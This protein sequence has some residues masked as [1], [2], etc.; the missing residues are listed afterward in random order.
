MHSK[1]ADTN[2]QSENSWTELVI[3]AINELYLCLSKSNGMEILM[4]A[5]ADIHRIMDEDA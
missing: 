1:S 4:L 3:F 5:H 2:T